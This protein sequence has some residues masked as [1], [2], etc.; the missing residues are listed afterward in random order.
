MIRVAWTL[1]LLGLFGGC[2]TPH[3]VLLTQTPANMSES[4]KAVV[5]VIGQPLS[6]SENGRELFSTYFDSSGLALEPAKSKERFQTHVIIL[7]DRRPYD[8]RVVVL[9]DEKQN[10]QFVPIGYDNQKARK[11]ADRIQRALNESRDKRNVI[12]DF[13]PF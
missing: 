11:I 9:V 6:I 4:R 12:D 2:Q 7:G 13:K 10:G 1:I 8:I 5:S 3:G